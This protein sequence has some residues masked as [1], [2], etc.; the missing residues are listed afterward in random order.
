MSGNEQT[1]GKIV[2]KYLLITVLF[3]G[4]VNNTLFPLDAYCHRIG[5]I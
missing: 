3:K 2:S 5:G 1:K 4:G